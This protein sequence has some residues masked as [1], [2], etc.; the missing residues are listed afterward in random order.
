MA[1][2]MTNEMAKDLS[3]AI[4]AAF[5]LDDTPEDLG[6]YSKWSQVMTKEIIRLE[7]VNNDDASLVVLKGIHT[8]VL[9]MVPLRYEVAGESILVMLEAWMQA[10]EGAEALSKGKR[11]SA[12]DALY[13]I[14]AVIES[15]EEQS[16]WPYLDALR[17]ELDLTIE[18]WAQSLSWFLDPGFEVTEVFDEVDVLYETRDRLEW[19][20]SCLTF[21]KLEFAGRLKDFDVDAYRRKTIEPDER[22]REVVR[23]AILDG[24]HQPDAEAP[25]SFWWRAAS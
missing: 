7:A 1:T 5:P 25:S 18:R 10:R 8:A 22:F 4:E 9:L 21:F 11:S 17:K 24:W 12:L 13:D 6:P 23:K 20:F 3:T 2:S 16:D 14:A 15:M 19:S